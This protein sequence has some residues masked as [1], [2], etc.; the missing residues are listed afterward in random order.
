MAFSTVQEA[1]LNFT[2]GAHWAQRCGLSQA[3]DQVCESLIACLESPSSRPSLDCF[4][5]RAD[6]PVYAF[7][8]WTGV[9]N[10]SAWS[11][12][13]LRPVRGVEGL[14]QKVGRLVS[15]ESSIQ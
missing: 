12:S 7:E 13:A 15:E 5:A 8:G 4:S 1:A 11:G 9:R 2:F 14:P 10:N 6:R 3:L